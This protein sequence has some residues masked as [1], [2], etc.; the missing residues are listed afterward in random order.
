MRASAK[1]IVGP[2]SAPP[3]FRV[4]RM[5][6]QAPLAWRPT[7]GGV[8]MVS[9]SASP[10]G[11]DD[12]SV[13]VRVGA[14]AHLPVRSSAALIAWTG[15]GSRHHL[16][17]DVEEA[18]SLDWA[19]EPLVATGGCDHDQTATVRLAAGARLRWCEVLVLGRSGEA[20]GRLRSHLSV[21][22]DGRPLLR[23]ELVSALAHFPSV[24]GANRVAGMVVSVGGAVWPAAGG[25][26]VSWPAGGVPVCG[27]VGGAPA[28]GGWATMPLHAG[29]TITLAVGADVP[30]I[31]DRLGRL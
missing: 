24:L 1:L 16:T 7:P 12:L 5:V 3:G 27:G 10:V 13:Y 29:G 30:A 18:G 6:N 2:S 26:G 15:R 31:L 8:Y 9:T 23:H 17:V 14:G 22:L 4:E 28:G 19:P 20:G 11:D 25:P 21:D